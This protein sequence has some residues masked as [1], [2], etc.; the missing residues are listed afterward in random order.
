VDK[1]S[2]RKS[3][4]SDGGGL[5]FFVGAYKPNSVSFAEAEE[6]AIYLGL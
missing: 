2:K 6:I 1:L 5:S 3:P 4:T